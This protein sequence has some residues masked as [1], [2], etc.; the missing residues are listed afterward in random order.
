VGVLRRQIKIK[1]RHQI[2]HHTHSPTF[3]RV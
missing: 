3:M 2:L 1:A